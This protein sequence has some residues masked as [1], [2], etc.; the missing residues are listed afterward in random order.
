MIMI[1]ITIITLLSRLYQYEWGIILQLM[2]NLFDSLFSPNLSFDLLSLLLVCMFF[3]K[4]SRVALMKK[5]HLNEVKLVTLLKRMSSKLVSCFLKMLTAPEYLF[6][7]R[8]STLN[9][10]VIEMTLNLYLPLKSCL[11]DRVC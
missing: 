4:G 7:Q 11:L 6:H 5:L 10:L 1:Q 3:T 2:R 9:Y 8:L